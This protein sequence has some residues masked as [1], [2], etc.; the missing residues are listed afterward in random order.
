M[1]F[2][3]DS[4]WRRPEEKIDDFDHINIR[5]LY[6]T[7]NPI[8]KAKRQMTNWGKDFLLLL[9]TKGCKEI[10]QHLSESKNK[11]FEQSSSTY[12][13]YRALG[14]FKGWQYTHLVKLWGNRRSPIFMM[15][16]MFEH[17]L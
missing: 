14:D 12:F 3:T 13:S 10:E 15:E 8:N 2:L 17:S 7:R 16:Y 1:A 4:K 5:N 11:A 6:I 9:Q